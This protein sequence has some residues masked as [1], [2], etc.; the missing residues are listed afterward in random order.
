MET[1][2]EKRG[3]GKSPWRN[4]LSI[5]LIL[6]GV[7]FIAYPH[8]TEFYYKYNQSQLRGIQQNALA[9]NRLP[10]TD[11]DQDFVAR[12]MEKMEREAERQAAK[13]Q[14]VRLPSAYMF[15]LEIPAIKLQTMVLK[16]TGVSVLR[17]APGYYTQSKMPG[18]GN[19]AIAGHR[20]TYGAPFRKVN[21]LKAGDPIYLTYKETR[22]VYEVERVFI[23]ANNDWSVIDNTKVPSLTLTTCHP[24][25]SDEQRMIVR[26]VLIRTE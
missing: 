24:I 7:G 17:K 15:D 9:A 14:E 8:F 12:Y 20:N 11:P 13:A 16:G 19:T 10:E 1:R 2:M 18:E 26:A 21:N 23:V 22:Y 25:G 6:I 3:S 5:L 4:I